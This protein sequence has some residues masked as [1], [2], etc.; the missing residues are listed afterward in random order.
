MEKQRAIINA[1]KVTQ[2][3]IAD[4]TWPEGIDITD[5]VP[6]PGIGWDYNGSTF[7]APPYV[8][9][10]PVPEIRH[11]TELSFWQRFT[12]AERVG[13]DLSSIDN[14]ASTMT[15][16][17]NAAGLRDMRQQVIAA[18]FIDLNRVD[19]RAGIQLRSRSR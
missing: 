15:E 14:P 9:P 8:E 4:E 19:T 6:R 7:T 11:I 17:S 18:E 13:I 12:Q 16:R 3:I 10:T 5:V 1:G 2:V